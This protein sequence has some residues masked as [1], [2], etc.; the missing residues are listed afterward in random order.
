MRCKNEQTK[1]EEKSI[2][3]CGNVL[4]KK[5]RWKWMVSFMLM[6]CHWGKWHWHPMDRRLDGLSGHISDMERNSCPCWESMSDIQPHSLALN[7]LTNLFQKFTNFN[8]KQKY[9]KQKVEDLFP[10]ST[11]AQKVNKT[12]KYPSD[13]PSEKLNSDVWKTDLWYEHVCY[14]LNSI[15]LKWAKSLLKF[16]HGY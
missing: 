6:L 11:S 8:L 7:T 9:T 13:L 5:K 1:T 3:T 15:V 12:M 14:M 16:L 10:S 4:R 2:H